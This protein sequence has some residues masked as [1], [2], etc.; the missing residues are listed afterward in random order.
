MLALILGRQS[1]RSPSP[2]N[3]GRNGLTR[4]TLGLVRNGWGFVFPARTHQLLA[5]GGL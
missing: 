1:P 2:S 3:A 5:G 4:G